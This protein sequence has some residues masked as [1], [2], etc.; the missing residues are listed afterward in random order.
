M[1]F[2]IAVDPLSAQDPLQPMNLG[3][4]KNKTTQNVVFL[5]A[6]GRG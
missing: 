4:L 3:I 2:G 6:G 1:V 5:V